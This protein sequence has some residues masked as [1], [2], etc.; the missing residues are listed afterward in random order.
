MKGKVDIV[1]NEGKE[2]EERINLP[3]K[4]VSSVYEHIAY[5]R[6]ANQIHHW[7]TK[8]EEDDREVEIAGKDILDLVEVC[9]KV[10]ASLEKQKLVKKTI[11]AYNGKL[12]EVELYEY[13]DLAQE[14]LPPQ[15]GF[16]FGSYI[17]DKWYK[18][19]LEDTIKM[20]EGNIDPDGWY[21]YTASY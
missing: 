1:I 15:E 14:F 9:K 3:V 2:Y 13:D 11:E 21:R 16:F 20:L 17:I 4:K 7:F 12:V 18:Q 19:D 6:K 8:N 5:W 10:L